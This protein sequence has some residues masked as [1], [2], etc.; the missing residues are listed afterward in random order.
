MKEQASI[1][2]KLDIL[3]SLVQELKL[4]IRT[5]KGEIHQLRSKESIPHSTTSS[6]EAYIDPDD[7][8]IVIGDHCEVLNKYKGLRGYQFKV[9]NV[10]N[11]KVYF[12]SNGYTTWRARK[13][14][15]KIAHKS[16]K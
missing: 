9:T 16:E 15:R 1:E 14:V 2:R 13:N 4:E 7:T 12:I 8:P 10:V 3:T 5:L 11:E 6:K